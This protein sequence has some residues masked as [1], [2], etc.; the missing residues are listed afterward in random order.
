MENNHPEDSNSF[1]RNLGPYSAAALIIG[2]VIGTGI[3]LF[4]SDVG[5]LMHR[6]SLIILVWITGGLIAL[7]EFLCLSELASVYPKTGGTYVFLQKAFGSFTAFEFVWANYFII[8]VGY[9]SIQMIA[10]TH[11]ASDFFSVDLNIYQKPIAIGLLAVICG[12]NSFGIKW[13]SFTQNI[14]VILKVSI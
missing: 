5:S 3:F 7:S 13:G 4:A 10:F 11:F 1:N 12:I 6:P 9:F 2:T 8:R 14:F